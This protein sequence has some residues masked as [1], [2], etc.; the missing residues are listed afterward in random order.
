ML[1]RGSYYLPFDVK[2]TA[3]QLLNMYHLLRMCAARLA[4]KD[5]TLSRWVQRWLEDM[6]PEQ[7]RGK[8]QQSRW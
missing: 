6:R 5:G 8:A 3:N 4:L 2:V 1:P 7:E